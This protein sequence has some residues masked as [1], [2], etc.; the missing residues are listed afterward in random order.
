MLSDGVVTAQ[1]SR[2]RE[3]SQ[4]AVELWRMLDEPG[5]SRVAIWVNRAGASIIFVSIMLTLIDSGQ[6]PTLGFESV[7][8]QLCCDSIFS[9]EFLV[10]FYCCPSRRVFLSEKFSWLEILASFPVLIVRVV[11]GLE[12]PLEVNT[13]PYLVLIAFTP[14]L[15]LL[16]M[17]RRFEQIHLQLSAF[18][19]AAAALPVLGYTLSTLIVF[20]GALLYVVEPRE[21][22][23]SFAE[24][25]WVTIVTSFTVGYG[26][27]YPISPTGRCVVC[28]LMFVSALYMAIPIGIVGDAFSQVWAERDALLLVRRMST[29]LRFAHINAH[30]IPE[31]F[32][33]F[34]VD[35]NGMINRAEFLSIIQSMR[36]NLDDS[37]ALQLFKIID[38]DESGE[39]TDEEF[40][41]VLFPSDFEDMYDALN[42]VVDITKL[43][44]T[45][46]FGSPQQLVNLG[47]E[48]AHRVRASVSQMPASHKEVLSPSIEFLRGRSLSRHGEGTAAKVDRAE[49]D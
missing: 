43:V 15:R 13:W 37:Q 22:I 36:V 34:D 44:A 25:L 9:I 21:N 49:T 42:S 2:Q 46:A 48:T 29:R 32:H 19:S 3:R 31:L 8:I 17:L 38:T 7:F 18:R 30:D 45:S 23:R 35:Q 14:V 47:T 41:K 10:R 26:D 11:G 27:K 39:I 40:V 28:G 33:R 20:F 6:E 16:L 12:W 4:F 5:S 24:A 1:Q